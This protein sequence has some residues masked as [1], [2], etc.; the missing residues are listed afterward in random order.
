M[1]KLKV[2]TRRGVTYQK[3]QKI[4]KCLKYFPE[5][6]TPKTLARETGINQNTIKSILPKLHG[7]KK[8]MRGLYKVVERGDTPLASASSRLTDWNFHNLILSCILQHGNYIL[9]NRDYEFGLIGVKFLISTS[10]RA[11]FRI[12]SDTPLNVSSISLAAAFFVHLIKEEH[13]AAPEPGGVIIKSIEFNKDYS[14]LRL[15]GVR[16]VTVDSLISQFKLYQK[17]LSMRIEHKTKVPFTVENIVDMLTQNPDSLEHNLKLSKQ[18]DMLDRLTVVTQRN[19]A[20]LQ[21]LLDGM[22]T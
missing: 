20:L 16:S 14:N 9:I 22:K 8:V 15:D 12:S 4:I 3:H 5:G 1:A 13:L 7:I 17:E 11:S 10:G 21:Q 19:T 18:A 6:A 2:S